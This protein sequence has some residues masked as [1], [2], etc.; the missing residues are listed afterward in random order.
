MRVI[1]V[2]PG[3]MSDG[4]LGVAEMARRQALL[5][6]WTFGG[7]AVEVV[8]VDNGV[9]SIESAYEELLSAPKTIERIQALEEEGCDAAIIGCFGDPGLEA[10]R[11]LVHIP[12]IGRRRCCSP[13][14][15][16]TASAFSPSS[17]VSRRATVSR[18]SA[19][20]CSTSWCRCAVSAFRCWN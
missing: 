3:A 14:S 2:V 8:D 17:T 13:R 11:E 19:P 10:A 1:Y 16:A 12:V 6:Q 15:S 18:P 4:P 7:T 5:Q 9:H 20:G